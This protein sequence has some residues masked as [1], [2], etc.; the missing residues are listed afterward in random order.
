MRRPCPPSIDSNSIVCDAVHSGRQACCW[1]RDSTYSPIRVSG[2]SFVVVL[3]E[4]AAKLPSR[5]RPALDRSY[6][7]FMFAVLYALKRH[8]YLRSLTLDLPFYFYTTAVSFTGRSTSDDTT[9]APCCLSDPETN[10]SSALRACAAGWLMSLGT[11]IL[12]RR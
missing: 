7:R 12:S 1:C 3:A 8:V 10:L 2:L 5:Q 9:N 6:F 11:P 4:Q